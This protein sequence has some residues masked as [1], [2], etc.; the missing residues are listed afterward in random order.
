MAELMQKG[1]TRWLHNWLSGC[2][3]GEW[4]KTWQTDYATDACR[5]TPTW[6]CT[7][8]SGVKDG[9]LRGLHFSLFLHLLRAALLL[10]LHLLVVQHILHSL[11]QL[12][13]PIARHLKG[14]WERMK[15]EKEPA[16]SCILND[17][18]VMG[19]SK[20]AS[21]SGINPTKTHQTFDQPNWLL[22]WSEMPQSN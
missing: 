17:Q 19:Q 4:V 21:N 15:D 12:L 16:L 3:L 10:F 1:L 6:V 11:L 18:D 8:R 20:L 7:W 9:A 13:T 2:E 22:W 5:Q 14:G